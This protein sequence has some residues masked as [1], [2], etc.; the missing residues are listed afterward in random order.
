MT[1]RITRP[2]A[3]LFVVLLAGMIIISACGSDDES[4]DGTTDESI[5]T[6]DT[7]TSADDDTTTSTVTTKTSDDDGTDDSTSTADGGAD[8]SALP[9]EDWDGFASAGDEFAVM[10]VVHDDELNVRSLPD[11]SSDII[12]SVG[13]TETGLIATGRA[14]MLPDSIWYEVD[15][16]GA[17]GWVNAAFVG[18]MGGTDDATSE[19]VAAGSQGEAGTMVDLGRAV[20][21]AFASEEPESRIVQSIAPTVGDLGEITYDVIGLGDDSVAGMRLHIFATPDTERETF[22]LKSIERTV[23]CSRGTD[24]ELCV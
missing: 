21:A 7:T 19:Y 17:V 15:V 18:F 14:R 22:S 13:P 6:T 20:A 11:A 10:G 1:T 24:G 16:D 23:F 12:T 5:D 9:G 2:L 8:D 3:R 4:T